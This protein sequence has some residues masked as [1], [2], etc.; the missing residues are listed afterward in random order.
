VRMRF[1]R[2]LR[3]LTRTHDTVASFLPARARSFAGKGGGGAQGQIR[4]STRPHRLQPLAHGYFR[5]RRR[6]RI[7][8]CAGLVPPVICGIMF[9]SAPSPLSPSHLRGRE[10]CAEYEPYLLC[11]RDVPPLDLRFTGYGG[12]K[13]SHIYELSRGGHVLVVLPQAFAVH[14]H[15][16]PGTALPCLLRARALPFTRKVYSSALDK[17]DVHAYA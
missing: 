1:E 11:R 4:E 9:Y 3:T 15:H 16:A 10:R 7:R 13:T 5:I 17:E 12:D 14:E 2:V 6:L 8:W